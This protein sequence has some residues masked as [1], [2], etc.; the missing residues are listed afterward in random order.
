M[1]KFPDDF[2]N[3][4]ICGDVSEVLKE[5]PDECVDVIITSPPYW[6]LRDY[7]VKGQIGL[8]KT[9]DEY[10]N[11][12]LKITA[13]L[14]RVLKPTG[15]MFWNHGDSYG[16]FQGKFARWPDQKL[17]LGENIPEHRKPK[18]Y[19]KCL[20][21]QNYRLA[22]RMADEQNWTWRNTI[23]WWK[24]NCM[25]SSTKDRFTV[26]YEPVFFFTKSKKYW[27]E[28]QFENF[29]SNK[30]D[31]KRMA[32]ARTEYGG[33]WAQES[34]GAIKTQRAFVAGNSLGRNKRCVWKIN[35]HPFPAAH[36]AVF[37]EALIETPIKAGCPEMLCKKCGR[38][39]E[40][41]IA[42]R[43]LPPEEWNDEL[44]ERLK[45]AGANKEGQY[46]GK[47]QK[48]YPSYIGGASDRKRR[49]LR[50]MRSVRELKG[51]TDCG[52]NAGWEPGI[53]LDPFVGAGTSCVV[54]KKFKRRWIGI[55]IS[56]EYCRMA[57]ERIKDTHEPL[58]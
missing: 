21:G 42:Q 8:E 14:K 37:P 33:K 4:I 48:D 3:K 53:V 5:M 38:A 34:G 51:H 24:P 17:K 47:N 40:K 28:P 11:K 22:L 41:I 55:D 25:P 54:A 29:E 58:F 27:F 56:K 39:R 16:G 43:E 12:L 1:R 35:T 49:I 26:D 36:F 2:V 32:N 6:G 7:Q 9:L 23:I 15:V 30:Y 44:K 10:L 19:A 52:C 57:R 46:Y 13:E 18:Q 50:A 20:L 45:K 31:L